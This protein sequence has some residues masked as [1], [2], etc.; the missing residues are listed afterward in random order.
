MRI[1]TWNLAGRWDERHL[2]LMEQAACDVWLLTEVSDHLALPG[3]Y[4][5]R[6]DATMARGRAWAGV[7]TREELRAR[8][9]PHPATAAAVTGGLT[10]WSSILPWRGCGGAPTWVGDRHVDKTRAACETLLSEQPAGALVWGGDWNH[11]LS[12]QEH[13]GSIGGRGAVLA[14]V[15]TAGLRVPTAELAHRIPG[16]L[17]IDHIAIPTRWDVDHAARTTAEADGARL[18]DHDLY[19]VEVTAQAAP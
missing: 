8:P 11:A 12:G 9:D 4:E 2:A 10:V 18:S 14:A 16:L 17:S 19:T 5:V 7:F 15:A 3:Y 13:A 6:T 1:G